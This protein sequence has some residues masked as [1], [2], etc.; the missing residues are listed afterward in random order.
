VSKL[1]VKRRELDVVEVKYRENPG[2]SAAAA[3][4]RAH[5]ARPVVIATERDFRVAEHY[6]LMPAHTLLWALG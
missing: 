6:A 5:P 3:A 2:L 1:A 4:A